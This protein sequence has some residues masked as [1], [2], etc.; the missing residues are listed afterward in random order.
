M[1]HNILN[2]YIGMQCID[3]CYL[4]IFII[5]AL[6]FT[7]NGYYYMMICNWKSILYHNNCLLINNYAVVFTTNQFY[8][9]VW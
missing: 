1:L 8:S 9:G 2:C 6:N 5:K 3:P 4:E 7:R